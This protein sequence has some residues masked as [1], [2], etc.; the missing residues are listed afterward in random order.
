MTVALNGGNLLLFLPSGN[1]N[2]EKLKKDKTKKKSNVGF[3]LI[4][5]KVLN[6][7]FL[8]IV[9]FLVYLDIVPHPWSAGTNLLFKRPSIK[10][11]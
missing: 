1:V 10:M 11:K 9:H 5:E 6:S 7:S 4:A 2:I 3:S 8:L